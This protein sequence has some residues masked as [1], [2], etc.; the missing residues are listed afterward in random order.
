MAVHVAKTDWMPAPRRLPTGV[1]LGAF[2]D[3]HGHLDQLNAL[4][5]AFDAELRR[6][7]LDEAAVVGLGD[8]NDRGPQ[9][10]RCFDRIRQ[11]L[12]HPASTLHAL[13]GNH[14]DI[15]LESMADGD[16]ERWSNWLYYGGQALIDELDCAPT[17]ADLAAA[18][19]PDR[20]AWLD[21]LPIRLRFG[22]YFLAHAGLHPHRPLADQ[23]AEDL[24]WIRKPFL[25]SPGPYDQG[26][27]VVHGH[28]PRREPDWAHAHRL[29]LDSGIY[30]SGRLTGVLFHGGRMRVIEVDGPVLFTPPL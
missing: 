12:D 16:R 28:T 26:V 6:L 21:A 25:A 10:I 20:S 24:M 2:G 5:D 11:G 27:C 18:V 15:L 1:A 3:V 9:S 30:M 19:G 17:P 7:D 4:L 8:V 29:N 23:A 14:E 22:P 13:R